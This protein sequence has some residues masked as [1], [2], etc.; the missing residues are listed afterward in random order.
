MNI[1]V[2]NLCNLIHLMEYSK[3]FNDLNSKLNDIQTK[4]FN[5]AGKNILDLRDP[6]VFY[7]D[8]KYLPDLLNLLNLKSI[9]DLYKN[10]EIWKSE[11]T[12]NVSDFP[13]YEIIENAIIFY[14]QRIYFF[15]ISTE[16]QKQF[17]S[18]LGE[19]KGNALINEIDE[20]IN[21]EMVC[22]NADNAIKD[23]KLFLNNKPIN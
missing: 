4:Y 3:G 1:S 22:G 2:P 13:I 16:E 19:E 9:K 11:L 8:Q 23:L 14:K 20:L 10:K 21:D 7:S 5:E 17:I 12:V 18:L 15:M 6:F